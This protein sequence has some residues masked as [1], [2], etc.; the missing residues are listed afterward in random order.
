VKRRW[1]LRAQLIFAVVVPAFAVLAGVAY[2]ADAAMRDALEDALGAQLTATAEAAGTIVDPKVLLLERG[3]D[4]LRVKK[5]AEKKLQ[6]LAVGSK[7]ERILVVR[8]GAGSEVLLDTQ[9]ELVIGAEYIRAAFDLAELEAVGRGESAASALFR[10]PD[11]R[12]YK[13]GY[14][15]LYNES[16]PP[17]V[18]AAIVVHAPASFFTILGRVRGIL[19]ALAALGFA[20]LLVLAA[21]S[22]RA[23][24]EPLS[25]LSRAAERIGKGELDAP[26][27]SGGPA[28]AEVLSETMRSMARSIAQREEEMQV[29]L[30]GIAHEVRN[31]LSGIELF[32]GLLR[33]DLEEGDP[34]RRSVDKILK[35]IGVLSGVVNDFLDY[36]RKR[37]LDRRP[38]D[39]H[40]VL[41]EIAG[42]LASD[43]EKKTIAVRV[44]AEKGLI[45]SLDRDPICR[46]LL[47]L[48]RNAI[49]AVPEGG[50]VTLVARAAQQSVEVRIVDDGPGIAKESREDVF[51]PFF[52]TKQK[53]TG[54]GLALVKKTVDAHGGTIAIEETPGGG[55]TFVL[56]FARD[57]AAHPR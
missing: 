3:D 52:T 29:M 18:E 2:F 49:Q 7:V 48:A 6:L 14:A 23:V 13:S 32:G 20:V 26:I 37:A 21:L 34:R 30:A 19:V 31:P 42:L 33:E 27:P 41:H 4:D 38:L 12:W 10:G 47:N 1:G 24:T 5:S 54:L 22:A 45:A 50:H 53:G 9:G 39:V 15:P 56:S 46:A 35:Q 16:D 43:A 40:E 55:A 51:R 11:E 17:K 25:A 36:V 57:V 8:F 28:E 44:D